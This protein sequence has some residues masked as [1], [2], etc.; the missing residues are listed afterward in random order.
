[1][2]ENR[3]PIFRHPRVQMLH[4]TT[5]SIITSMVTMDKLI[6]LLVTTTSKI[7]AVVLIVIIVSFV[8]NIVI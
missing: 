1:M 8:C 7:I 2:S 6:P 3:K 5:A 4:N